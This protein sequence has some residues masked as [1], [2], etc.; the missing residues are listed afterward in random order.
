MKEVFLLLE[1]ADELLYY[2]KTI[3]FYDTSLN[4]ILTEAKNETD[5]NNEELKQGLIARTIEKIKDALQRMKNKITN[6][7]NKLLLGKNYDEYVEMC[8]RLQMDKRFNGKKITVMD[9]KRMQ[10]ELNKAKSETDK[11]LARAP[12]MTQADIDK[13]LARISGNKFKQKASD[14][15]GKVIGSAATV[16]GIDALVRLAESNRLCAKTI[17]KYITDD[18]EKMREIE[19]TIGQKGSKNLKKRVESSSKLLSV[20]NFRAKLFG[21][22]SNSIGTAF[23]Q[24]FNDVK[25]AINKKPTRLFGSSLFTTAD[26][27]L[28]NQTGTGAIGWAANAKDAHKLAKGTKEDLKKAK[29]KILNK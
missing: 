12:Y 22:T 2:N 19:S 28:K 4:D 14:I 20:Y 10:H 18:E 21:Q 29:N 15:G 13:E 7:M 1:S 11:L 27:T 8:K 9:F 6:F 16:I 23:Q 24:V 25:G 26:S 17:K 5:E 3:P